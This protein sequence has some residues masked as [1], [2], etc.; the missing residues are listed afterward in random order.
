MGGYCSGQRSISKK[1]T[2]SQH[3]ID[4]RWMKKQNYLYPGASGIL[5]WTC[6]GEI[7]GS[8][9]FKTETDR[10]V[11]NY[12]T[13]K[14]REEWQSIE[15]NIPLTWTLCNYG[16]ARQWFNCPG[17]GRRVGLVY[18]GKY[19]RCRHCHNLTYKSQQMVEEDRA[20]EKARDIRIKLGGSVNLFDPFPAKPK[21]MHWKTYRHLQY[22]AVAAHNRSL[23]IGSKR[24]G[25]SLE[26]T[27]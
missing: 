21:N 25:I 1:T 14:R 9:N 23:L 16:G 24:L 27:I 19:F 15:D 22:T 12:R 4:I 10:L 13:R 20:M 6:R 11:L 5:K 3:K 7:S 26:S 18:G 2:A 17:C 8:I